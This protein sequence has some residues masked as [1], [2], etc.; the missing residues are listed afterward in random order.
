MT[1][2]VKAYTITLDTTDAEYRTDV[3]CA[4]SFCVRAISGMMAKCET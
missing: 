1:A 2:N 4:R 3:N